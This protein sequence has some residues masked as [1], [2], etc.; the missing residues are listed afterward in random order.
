MVDKDKVT[1]LAA[2]D[3][4]GQ[5]RIGRKRMKERKFVV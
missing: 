2:V 3:E 5:Q 1:S 4:N